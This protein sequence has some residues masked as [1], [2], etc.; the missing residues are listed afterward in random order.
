MGP[1]L[2]N[3]TIFV[4]AVIW[5]GYVLST[6]WCNTHYGCVVVQSAW[7]NGLAIRTTRCYTI[8][9]LFWSR[10]RPTIAS[11]SRV[12]WGI[13]SMNGLLLATCSSTRGMIARNIGI[14]GSI[15]SL[16]AGLYRLIIMIILG[17]MTLTSLVSTGSLRVSILINKIV[18][19]RRVASTVQLLLVSQLLFLY[20]K[21]TR[22]WEG[23]AAEGAAFI[24]LFCWV[25]AHNLQW[26]AKTRV[27]KNWG[28]S[29]V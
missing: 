14:S 9:C 10:S 20:R 15:W 7:A 17:N 12:A 24:I 4:V 6:A 19:A 25:W 21:A 27:C 26:Y 28:K 18:I 2:T 8:I 16:L 11:R 22:G 13:L 1:W 23:R 5:G 3:A 29:I